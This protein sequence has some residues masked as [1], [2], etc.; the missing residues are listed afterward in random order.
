MR[1]ILNILESSNSL[2]SVSI[3][4][5]TELGSFGDWEKI[6][7]RLK[8]SVN[9]VKNEMLEK[10]DEKT[11]NTIIS[12]LNQLLE[13]VD[14]KNL[15]K[16]VGLF[17]TKTISEKIDFPFAVDN[18]TFVTEG[19]VTSDIRK[20]IAMLFHYEVLILSRKETRLFKGWGNSLSEIKD[21]FPIAFE[22][23]FQVKRSDPHAFYSNEESKVND[24]RRATYFRKIAELVNQRD[25][26][27]PLVLIGTIENASDFKN[28]KKCRRSILV[29]INGNMDKTRV[30]EIT[31]TVWE[32]VKPFAQ[33]QSTHMKMHF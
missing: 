9:K 17:A 10:F 12:N 15:S 16:G 13:T 18:R 5:S 20:N 19:F 24:A 1:D 25:Q 3:I 7:I 27:V 32:K 26:E 28:T 21:D 8:E 14:Y 4:M 6:A 33:K 29:E 23:E 2:P 22:N 30:S 11:V 31:S